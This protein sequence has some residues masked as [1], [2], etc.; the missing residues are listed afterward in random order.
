M[1]LP[2]AGERPEDA[3]L[4]CEASLQNTPS[5]SDAYWLNPVGGSGQRLPRLLRP[6]RTMDRDADPES[7]R[8]ETT[9]KYDEA[10]WYNSVLLNEAVAP[11][12]S[13]GVQLPAAPFTDLRVSLRVDE[14]AEEGDSLRYL[15]LRHEASSMRQLMVRGDEHLVELG[16]DRWRSLIR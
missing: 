12:R 3:A 1:H 13:D 9:F 6:R 14:D 8:H 2:G 15:T 16:R 10:I 4:S 5:T 11:G 7:R